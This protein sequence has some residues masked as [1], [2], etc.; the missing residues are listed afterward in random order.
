MSSTIADHIRAAATA[1]LPLG[2]RQWL[3]SQQ[4]R[5]GLHRTRV[6][7]VAFGDLRRLSPISPVFGVDRGLPVIDRYYI[8]EFLAKHAAD[9]R[10]EVLE[11]GDATYT[12]RF[13]GDRVTRSDVMHY[14]S[15]NPAATIVGD[16]A[17]AH[18]IQS[19]RF[20]CIVVTQTLQM[21]LDV[22]AAL[23]HLH[24]IL[25]PGGVL[26]ATSHGIS[27][28]A[29]R[30]GIDPWGEY[31]HFTAQ[32]M[33]HLVGAQFP[34]DCVQ[35]VTYGNVLSAAASLYGLAAADLTKQE[36]DYHDPNF[37]VIIAVRAQKPTVAPGQ[38]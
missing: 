26:L 3:R 36:L 35:T 24:R 29:R 27:R 30:E 1:L 37:E 12:R 14:S 23:H 5:F 9:I 11:M 13:G 18:S 25:K 15:G 2:L 20:D 19:N 22:P 34:A 33:G 4:R 7:G 17:T 32:A 28:I 16:L 6:G 8:E 10:G 21:I 38:N 31:W